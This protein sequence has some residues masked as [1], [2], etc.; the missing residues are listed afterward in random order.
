MRKTLKNSTIAIV[1]LI[2]ISYWIYNGLQNNNN[3]VINISEKNDNSD[4]IFQL[5]QKGQR[6]Q[7]S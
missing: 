1:S 3:E 4:I 6:P 7:Y 5:L 2:A